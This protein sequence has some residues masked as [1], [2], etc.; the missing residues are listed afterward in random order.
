LPLL[1][2]IGI[3]LGLNLGNILKNCL[4]IKQGNPTEDS[5]EGKV[6]YQRP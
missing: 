1:H 2:V 4:I 6:D 5:Q 3:Q